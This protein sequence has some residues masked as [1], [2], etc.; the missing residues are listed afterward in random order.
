M[1]RPSLGD[2]ADYNTFLAVAFPHDQVRVLPYNRIVKDL[3]RLT[4]DAFIQAVR[5]RFELEAGPAAP[6]RRGDISMYFGGSWHTLRPRSRPDAT[7]KDAIGS[8]DVSVLQDQLL[9]PSSAS[10][11]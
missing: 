5:D 4:P 7:D 11:T 9:S 2:G 1:T 6:V 8:L 10:R 3:G